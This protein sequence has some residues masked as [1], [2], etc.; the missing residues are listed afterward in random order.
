MICWATLEMRLHCRLKPEE[1]VNHDNIRSDKMFF[2]SFWCNQDVK[3]IH[4]ICTFPSN[5]LIQ[6]PMY[7]KSKII[8]CYPVQIW[9]EQ[10]PTK[11]EY[12][13]HEINDSWMWIDHKTVF[14][15]NPLKLTFAKR[16]LNT[17]L[18]LKLS[19]TEEVSDLTWK[20][21]LWVQVFMSTKKN[22]HL[23]LL[24]ANLNWLIRW[25]QVWLLINWNKITH[26][27]SYQLSNE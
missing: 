9:T 17:Q 5:T 27:Y 6:L 7:M 26:T 23:S 3:T 24:K 15:T 14:F 21:P 20:G 25:N 2:G 18:C 22:P 11:K 13:L 8:E 19:F 12:H 1:Y 10:T 16:L 4:F